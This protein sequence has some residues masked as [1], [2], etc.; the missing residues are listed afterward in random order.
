MEWVLSP[1]ASCPSC[2]VV[3]GA[4]QTQHTIVPL[5]FIS[6]CRAYKASDLSLTLVLSSLQGFLPCNLCCDAIQAWLWKNSCDLIL[7]VFSYGLALVR[8]CRCV[9]NGK[10]EAA[11]VR[12]GE[13]PL[14]SGGYFIVRVKPQPQTAS[15]P[16]GVLHVLQI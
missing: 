2:F 1:L 10:D 3:A 5:S 9:L 8:N 7:V 13:C 12:A 6:H 15:A 11:L 16:A 14:D 4:Q